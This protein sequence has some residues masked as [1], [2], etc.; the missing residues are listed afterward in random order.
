MI[1]KRL[2]VAIQGK[3]LL[4]GFQRLGCGNKRGN[5]KIKGRQLFRRNGSWMT[6]IGIMFRTF[7]RKID[8]LEK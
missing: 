3:R 2:A 7:L 5:E 8:V 6:L 1:G 4:L